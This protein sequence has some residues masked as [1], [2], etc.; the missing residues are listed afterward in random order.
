MY[1]LLYTFGVHSC[2]FYSGVLRCQGSSGPCTG[3]T[4]R[5]TEGS[6]GRGV[7]EL[8]IPFV[9]TITQKSGSEKFF[10]VLT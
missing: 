10:L 7:E 8:E 1:I 3:G 5:W 9:G 6:E 2:L 4:G